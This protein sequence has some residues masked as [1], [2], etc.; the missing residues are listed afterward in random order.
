MFEIW[1][2]HA[3]KLLLFVG[4]TRTEVRGLKWSALIQGNNG[5]LF[6]QFRNLKIEP[7]GSKKRSLLNK[8]Y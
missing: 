8:I 2:V 3:F 1:M 5:F 7:L 6:F 4:G